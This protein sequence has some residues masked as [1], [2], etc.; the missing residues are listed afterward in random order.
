MHIT[1][2]L[3][4]P[5]GIQKICIFFLQIFKVV[6]FAPKYAHFK[7]F[8]KIYYSLFFKKRQLGISIYLVNAIITSNF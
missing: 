8:H 5:V 4:I 3:G 6:Y 2:Y 7:K 1:N